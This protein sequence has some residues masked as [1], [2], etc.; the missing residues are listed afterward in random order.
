M[1][2]QKEETSSESV[3]VSLLLISQSSVE[4]YQARLL[5]NKRIS[6]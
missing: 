4:V 2:M 6:G 3:A 5:E 1:K